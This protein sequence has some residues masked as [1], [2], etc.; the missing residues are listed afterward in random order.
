MDFHEILYRGHSLKSVEETQVR[1]IIWHL[2]VS[3][4]C[5]KVWCSKQGASGI[6]D[7]HLLDSSCSSHFNYSPLHRILGI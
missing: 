5:H 6:G 1:F 3:W 4:I 2:N 7:S